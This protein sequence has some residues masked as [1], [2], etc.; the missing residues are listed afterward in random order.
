[1]VACFFHA[2][3]RS[4]FKFAET[5]QLCFAAILVQHTIT[6]VFFNTSNKYRQYE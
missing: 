1:V 2:K 5:M 3:F 6:L 4:V